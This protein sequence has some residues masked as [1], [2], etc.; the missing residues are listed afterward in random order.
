MLLIH[1]LL[2]VFLMDPLTALGSLPRLGSR[3]SLECGTAPVDCGNGWCCMFGEICEAA[4]DDA[5]V[6]IDSILTN[7]EG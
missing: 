7:S 2:L 6:C 1:T 5:F 4:D 3:Q